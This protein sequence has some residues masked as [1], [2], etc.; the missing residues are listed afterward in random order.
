MDKEARRELQKKMKES[1]DTKRLIPLYLRELFLKKSDKNHYLT[2]EQLDNYL[3]QNDVYADRRTIY[4]AIGILNSVGFEIEG[5]RAKGGE[6]HYFHTNRDFD[7]NEIKFLIDSVA[8]SKFLTEKKSLDLIKK[9]KKLGTDFDSESFNRR[10][11]L[12]KRVK[13]MNDKV[14]KNLDLIYSAISSNSKITFKYMKW[15]SQKKLEFMR[16]EKLFEVSPHAITLN[17]D[18]YYLISFDS[19]TKGLRNY[20]IDKMNSIKLTFEEREGHDLFKRFDIVDYSQKAFGMFNGNEVSVSVEAPDKLVGVFI[21]RFGDSVRIRPSLEKERY[22]VA[23]FTVYESIQFYGWLFGL[24]E[25]VKILSPVS[26]RDNYIKA[27]NSVIERIT[28]TEP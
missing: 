24:G 20:R 8:S 16:S 26:V 9:I 7:S 28:P 6:Y 13:S 22:F 25:K 3:I 12:S 1:S 10:I 5:V 2:F 4:S 21:E 23:H 19:R 11:L 15:N 14:F 17:D 27:L 18:N